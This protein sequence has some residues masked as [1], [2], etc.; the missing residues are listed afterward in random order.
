VDLR[1]RGSVDEQVSEG[2]VERVN[3]DRVEIPEAGTYTVTTTKRGPVGGDSALT[4]GKPLTT[5]VV[6]RARGALWGLLGFVLAAAIALVTLA[7]SSRS[8]DETVTMPPPSQ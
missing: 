2:A 4:F 6:D 7:T 5:G 8:R 1:G 3:F